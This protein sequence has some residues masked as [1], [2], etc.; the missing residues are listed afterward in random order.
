MEKNKK[1][2]ISGKYAP[3]VGLASGFIF[4][5]AVFT[6]IGNNDLKTAEIV[7]LV[8][9]CASSMSLF[10]MAADQGKSK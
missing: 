2:L 8:G 1:K 6:V 9:L 4:L 7:G 3:P 10:L 5:M